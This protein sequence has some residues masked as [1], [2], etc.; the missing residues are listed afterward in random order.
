MFDSARHDQFKLYGKARTYFVQNPG[1]LITLEKFLS[2][3]LYDL[4]D[5]NIDEI[6]FD[7][8]EASKLYPFWQNYPPDQR[9]RMPKGDQYPWI[10]VGEQ[11]FGNKL[12]R[13]LA[14]RFKLR[15]AG[16]PSGPDKRMIMSSDDITSA[17]SNF[18]D[19][20]WLFLDIKSV[21]PR[22]DQEHAVM[23]HNQV[24]GDGKWNKED[25]PEK[26]PNNRKGDQGISQ[27]PRCNSTFI[28]FE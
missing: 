19:S 5:A 22:D 12:M 6:A 16:L 9:G 11:V 21:G 17:C 7:Y 27:I 25:T 20:C 13:L 18:T 8:N 4:I 3:T 2:D 1:A 14:G 23:S 15:D 10:E 26:H 24:S 28:C